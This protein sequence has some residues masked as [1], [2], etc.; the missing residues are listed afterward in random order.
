MVQLKIY[1]C[2]WTNPVFTRDIGTASYGQY[3]KKGEFSFQFL[4]TVFNSSCNVHSEWNIHSFSRCTT[5]NFH[6][7]SGKEKYVSA[8]LLHCNMTMN[9]QRNRNATDSK[10]ICWRSVRSNDF[11]ETCADVSNIEVFRNSYSESR[12]NI[13]HRQKNLINLWI[14]LNN[15]SQ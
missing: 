1:E 15:L 7:N 13:L 10:A 11:Q 9:L 5:Q 6:F 8:S 12:T 3:R 2:P 14:N 4:R